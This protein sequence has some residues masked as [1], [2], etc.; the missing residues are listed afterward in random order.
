MECDSKFFHPIPDVLCPVGRKMIQQ[1]QRRCTRRLFLQVRN[2]RRVDPFQHVLLVLPRRFLATEVDC[3][4]IWV[5]RKLPGGDVSLRLTFEDQERTKLI[6]VRRDCN[7]ASEAGATL[8]GSSTINSCSADKV[9]SRLRMHGQPN[10]GLIHVYDPSFSHSR[11][12]NRWTNVLDPLQ[13]QVHCFLGVNLGSV[14]DPAK[15]HTVP[16][17]KTTDS[18]VLCRCRQLGKRWIDLNCLQNDMLVAERDSMLSHLKDPADDWLF[19]GVETTF[20]AAVEGLQMF[21][22]TSQIIN[23]PFPIPKLVRL[24]VVRPAHGL[25]GL[26]VSHSLVGIRNHCK[27]LADG[28]ASSYHDDGC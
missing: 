20:Q 15:A 1:Q 14:G 16:N 4:S 13:G 19:E 9:E 3:N 12:R 11:S 26:T 25:K 7:G 2:Q 6:A 21:P 27:F 28:K 23:F 10:R 24:D 5:S 18:L 22:P 17:A 8:S